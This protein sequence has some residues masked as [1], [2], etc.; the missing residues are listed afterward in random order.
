MRAL[1]RIRGR[2]R[3]SRR[4]MEPALDK[5]RPGGMIRGA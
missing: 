3:E 4:G 1:G 2:A 5:K